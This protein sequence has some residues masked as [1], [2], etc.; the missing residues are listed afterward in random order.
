[1]AKRIQI[2]GL[3]ELLQQLGGL[4]NLDMGAAPEQAAEAVKEAIQIE[5][6]VLTGDLKKA[7]K[8]GR[9]L[10]FGK[11]AKGN[12]TAYVFVDGRD[13]APANQ[14]ALVE[15]GTSK[16]PPNPFFSRGFARAKGAALAKLE[17]GIRAAIDKAI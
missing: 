9:D 14:G 15:F 4:A 2:E 10:P 5:A 11:R 17:A 8:S 3:D 16:T 7:I 1:M 13:V 12:R 6:P